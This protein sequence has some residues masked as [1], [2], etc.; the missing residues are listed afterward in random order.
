MKVLLYCQYPQNTKGANTTVDHIESF[1]NYSSFEVV[2][3]TKLNSFP[4]EEFLAKFDCFVIHHSISLIFDWY[5]SKDILI[6]IRNFKGIKILFIQ[7]EYRR[8]NFVCT[9]INFIGIDVLFTC[10]PLKVAR[11]IYSGLNRNIK[12]ETVLTGYV[13][14]NL[15]N[16]EVPL[17]S[18]REVDIGYRA[19]K[20][21]FWYGCKS[22]EKFQIGDRFTEYSRGTELQN[23]I[24]WR[25]KDRLY[26]QEWIKFISNCKATLGTESGASII[27]FTGRTEYK[28]NRFQAFR[29]FAHFKDVPA[30]LLEDDG[31][32]EIQV[33]SPRCFEAAALQT[34]MVLYPGSYS[35]I[36][37]K[38]KHYIELK[39][40]FS[41]FD[42][43]YQKLKVTDFLNKIAYQAKKDLV[44]SGKYTYSKFIEKFDDEVIR[45]SEEKKSKSKSVAFTA[46]ELKE[47]KRFQTCTP[48]VKKKNQII[49]LLRN[50]WKF[51][52]AWLSFILTVTVLKR[53]Y[54]CH[55]NKEKY[56]YLES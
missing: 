24:S 55:F 30:K 7:D 50:I 11:S 31:K 21:P 3:W 42:E 36:L 19:R 39:K 17:T 12:I 51:L 25:E 35:N 40:D 28:I 27:D 52:P 41:N 1:E 32:L 15:I 44:D 37:I 26:G 22:A 45:V 18:E 29:P 34:V 54:Y 2:I 10:A 49:S 16:I 47:I 9:K 53:K 48:S 23:D 8:V 6:K 46:Q 5:V 33:I 4:S 43:V 14:E 56:S 20:C 13:P 38:D